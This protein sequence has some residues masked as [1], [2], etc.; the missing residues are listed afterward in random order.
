VRPLRRYSHKSLLYLQRGL[1][2]ALFFLGALLGLLLASPRIDPGLTGGVLAISVACLLLVIL[3]GRELRGRYRFAIPV[4]KSPLPG[5][6]IRLVTAADYDACEAI[7]RL[8]E[9]A[10]FPDGY[11]D[12]FCKWLREGNNLVLIIEADGQVRACGGVAKYAASENVI[13]TYGMVHPACQGKRFGTALL[14]ARLAALPE[15]SDYWLVRM[16]TVGGS[17]SF[18]QRFGFDRYGSFPHETGRVFD[19]YFSRLSRR[20]WQDCRSELAKAP[21]EL[22]MA[23]AAVPAIP[24]QA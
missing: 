12:R 1:V 3:I 24:Q 7:Y 9:P 11:F 5:C 8:N 15:P 13:L 20:D 21:I 10:H 4:L 19:W 22:N 6:L 23:G 14:L 2:F 16:S 17:H 18:L